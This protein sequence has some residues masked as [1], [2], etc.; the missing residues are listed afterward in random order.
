MPPK[1]TVTKKAPPA[2]EKK[3]EL[4]PEPKNET[5]PSPPLEPTKPK[6]LQHAPIKKKTG[7]DATAIFDQKLLQAFKDAFEVIDANKD[8][9]IDKKDLKNVYESV[10]QAVTDDEIDDM[11]K[12]CDGPLDFDKFVIMF[13]ER[14]S[15]RDT[16][17]E[18]LAGFR[19]FDP[20]NTGK[21]TLDKLNYLLANPKVYPLNERELRHA[22]KVKLPVIGGMLD[23]RKYTAMLLKEPLN[24]LMKA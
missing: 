7:K 14:Y 23:Y 11:L 1:R 20:E 16:E 22:N 19:K 9:I 24:L 5:L 12:E 2:P 8:G 10:G 4:K 13:G 21:I 3:P 6:I 15:C 18:I 17:E